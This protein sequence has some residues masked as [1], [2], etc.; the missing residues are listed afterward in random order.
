MAH[1]STALQTIPLRTVSSSQ[2][3]YLEALV[4]VARTQLA[5]LRDLQRQLEAKR[6]EGQALAAQLA[7]AWQGVF[8]ATGLCIEDLS[9][10]AEGK[11]VIRGL[12]P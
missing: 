7:L 10:D 12:D 1:S 9:I 11:V 4:G 2:R 3:A 8:N 6:R 5:E